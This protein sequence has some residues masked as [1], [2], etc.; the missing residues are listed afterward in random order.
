[1]CD[2]GVGGG[3]DVGGKSTFSLTRDKSRHTEHACNREGIFYG[4]GSW[5]GRR[6]QGQLFSYKRSVK[7]GSEE[8]ETTI[9]Q[10]VT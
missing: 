7:G 9:L 5:Q 4:L 10:M 1:M 3:G 8:R 6:G 2:G